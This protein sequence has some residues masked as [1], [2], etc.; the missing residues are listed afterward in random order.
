MGG[1]RSSGE[2]ALPVRDYLQLV[3]D[4]LLGRPGVAQNKTS[5]ILR[6]NCS[7]LPALLEGSVT[8]RRS[9]GGGAWI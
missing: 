2:G 7:R 5:A 8:N 4:I 6:L 9:S 3:Y 1:V